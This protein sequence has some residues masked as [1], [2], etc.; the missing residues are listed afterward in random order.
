MNVPA[1]V[2]VS[3]AGHASLRADDLAAA[4]RALEL[5]RDDLQAKNSLLCGVNEN[6]VLAT[7]DARKL[8]EDAE[9]ANQRQNE[10]L[11]ML[12]HELRNPLAPISL[13]SSLLAKM[14]S[15]TVQLLTLQKTIDRQ[16]GHL[17]R[18]LDDLLDAARINTGKIALM[19]SSIILED[20]L[21]CAMETV[22]ARITQ[23]HQSMELHIPSKDVVLFGDPVRLGQ[24]FSNVLV[25]AS[26]FTQ[27]GGKI[28]ISSW[29]HEG[30]V[31]ITIADNGVGIAPEVLPHIF[32]LFTQGPRALA[33]SEGGLGVGLNVVRNVIQ[34]HGGT[35]EAR[36]P[37]IGQGTVFTIALPLP[38][39]SDFAV[40][41]AHDSSHPSRLHRILLVE[42][43][44]DARE[45]LC[46]FLQSE[47]YAVVTAD[48]GPEG[49][50][51]ASQQH[52]D[53]LVCDIG[54]PGING[55]DLIRQL[56]KTVGAG[57]PFCV[58]VS[59]YGQLQDKAQAVEAGFDEYMVKPIDINALLHLLDAIPASGV[60]TGG[61]D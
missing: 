55:Y 54:L 4:L 26:K 32:S 3:Q 9:R 61:D 44:G 30:M 58:A 41:E 12:A 13:A 18:L 24:V 14:P 47:G 23:R 37:G 40:P 17:S 8:R 7:L 34:L 27:D 56:R 11:A 53:V 39:L 43:N 60:R 36:S 33:R 28:I 49:L 10:F 31:L 19:R 57:A 46:M 25:N 48:D 1:N 59:G 38:A 29:V 15:P 5:E 45:M 51:L 21:V 16:V 35:V 2:N 52:F 50:A 42:D 22:Q 6:L 20:Q